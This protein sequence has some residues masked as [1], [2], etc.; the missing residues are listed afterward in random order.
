MSIEDFVKT[1]MENPV[2]DEDSEYSKLREL[3]FDKFG[4]II[5]TE[6]LPP[7]I[8]DEDI[9]EAI[10]K[11]LETGNSNIF[12]ILNVNVDFKNLY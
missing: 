3:Y 4:D 10:R 8:S 9:K 12:E 7:S 6:M 11:C 1:I 5:P 2:H